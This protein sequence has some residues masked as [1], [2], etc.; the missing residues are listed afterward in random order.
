MVDYDHVR[1]IFP[2]NPQ[3]FGLLIFYSNAGSLLPVTNDEYVLNIR[4][5]DIIIH[6]TMTSIKY[7]MYIHSL[8]IAIF[9]SLNIFFAPSGGV[10][11]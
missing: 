6:N 7:K 10:S 4:F 5:H 8:I 3:I 11:R 9:V 2:F 1:M